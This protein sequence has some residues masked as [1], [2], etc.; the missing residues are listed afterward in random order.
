MTMHR[1]G[2][3]VNACQRH[4]ASRHSLAENTVKHKVCTIQAILSTN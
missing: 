4:L 1:A 3:G 2:L